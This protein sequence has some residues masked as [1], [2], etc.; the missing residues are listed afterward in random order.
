MADLIQEGSMGFMI[1][2]DKFDL[3]RGFKLSTYVT[4]WIRQAINR[5]ISNKGETIRKSESIITIRTK[6][7][8]VYRQLIE[9]NQAQ[10]TSEELCIAYNKQCKKSKELTVEQVAELGRQLHGLTSLDQTTAEGESLSIHHFI[11]DDRIDIEGDAETKADKER[12]W[13][14]I[15]EL[16]EEQQVFV[17]YKYG[18]IDQRVKTNK[19]LVEMF[20]TNEKELAKI[21]SA[22]L[23]TL[24]SIASRSEINL[25]IGDVEKPFEMFIQ[26]FGTDRL[27]VLEELK[28][29]GYELARFKN[30]LGVWEMPKVLPLPGEEDCSYSRVSTLYTKL[31]KCGLKGFIRARISKP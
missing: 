18:L 24:R 1:G 20:A 13:K 25:E 23:G 26:D 31:T 4:W 21:D 8:G 14:Y 11:S 6:L 15:Y 22:I 27:G 2:L 7:R 3:G 19:E 12:L 30:A 28:S 29:L 17:I 10:P 16:P 9:K 5:A